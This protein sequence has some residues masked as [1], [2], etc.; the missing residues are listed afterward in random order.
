MYFNA[1]LLYI[2][3]HIAYWRNYCENQDMVFFVNIAHPYFQTQFCNNSNFHNT[4]SGDI[5]KA[6]G[7]QIWSPPF[8]PMSQVC[9]WHGWIVPSKIEFE[10]E[11]LQMKSMDYNFNLM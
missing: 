2:T 9:T 3:I 5:G 1:T 6:N 4:T 10:I 7:A 8:Q 11:T